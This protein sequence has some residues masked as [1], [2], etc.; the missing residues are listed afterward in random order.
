M[1]TATPVFSADGL[2][3]YFQSRRAGWDADLTGHLVKFIEATTESLECAIYDLRQPEVLAALARVASRGKRLR[4]VFD[5]SKERRGG[6][7]GDPKPNG[8]DQALEAAGLIGHCMPVFESGRHIMHDKFLVRDGKAV[9]AGS[10]N[11]TTGGLTLQDNNC[12][13]ATSPALAAQ[14]AAV[15][16]LLWTHPDHRAPAAKAALALG[17]AA[18]APVFAPASGE[19]IEHTLASALASAKRVRI[20]AFLISD[21]G[22]LTALARFRDDPQLDIRGVYD[23][24]G[25]QDVLRYS[26]QD[27]ALFWFTH[28]PRFVAAPSHAFDPAHEQD[29]MH[30]KAVIIDDR[31]VYTGS[32]NFSEN[33]EANDENVMTIESS[34]VAAAYTAYMEAL[35]AAYTSHAGHTTAAAAPAH[36]ATDATA[37]VARDSVSYRED[38]SMT[39]PAMEPRPHVMQRYRHTAIPANLPGYAANRARFQGQTKVGQTAHLIVYSDGSPAGDASAKAVLQTA[40]AD[41]TAVNG[42]FGGLS[43][44]PGHAG[45]DQNTPRTALPIQVLMD[46]QAGGAYHY[47]C[48]ATDLYCQPDP[49]LASGFMVAELVEIFEAAINNGWSCGQTNG[50]GLSRVLAGERNPH[51]ATDLVGPMQTWWGAGHGDYI[52]T[53]NATDQDENSNGCGPLFLYYLHSQLGYSWTQIITT[54]GA[55]LGACYQKLTG[56]DPTQGVQDFVSR[57]ATLDQ[58]GQLTLPASGNPFP[59]GGTAQAGP[60]AP[61]GAGAGNAPG[62]PDIPITVGGRPNWGLIIAIILIIIVVLVILFAQLATNGHLGF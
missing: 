51:L 40:E 8:T 24:H 11:F 9:W 27:Q 38:L 42:W 37:G 49:Q 16:E 15:F 39:S 13:V 61:G 41:Y 52:T 29:F 31:V 18:I 5:A 10:A 45:D 59:I 35:F 17:G 6:L 32:Y 19:G 12:V 30:N 2:E 43:L 46:A 26:K 44:P 1:A 21:P 3:I 28:D 34:A 23:P 58:G 7:E 4:I 56:R 57:L 36:R 55:T 14:Y 60:S 25:M 47:G 33:A 50:E 48:D 22:I 20:L 53:N 54:G 62:I